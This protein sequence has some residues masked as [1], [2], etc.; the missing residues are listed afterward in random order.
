MMI[1]AGV[2]YSL[3]S[4]SVCVFSGDTWD[5]KQCKFYYLAKRAKSIVTDGQFFGTEYPEFTCDAHRYDNLGNWVYNI[6]SAA[7]VEEVFIE[8]YAFGATGRVFQIAENTGMLKHALWRHKIPFDTFPPTVIKKFASGV[9][10]AKKEKMEE[11][12]I[13]ETG[14]NI[15]DR[16]SLSEKSS[17]PSSDI[18]D[19]Y[20]IAKFGWN[21]LMKCR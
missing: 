14:I 7:G 21:T 1:I 16:L 6:V 17:N 19:A 15:R 20:F 8:G 12:F 13:A 9:G 18:I 11:A 2:D 10:N 3:T 5:W 4:P